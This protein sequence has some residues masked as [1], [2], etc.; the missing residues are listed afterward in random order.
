MILQ[1][2]RGRYAL[3]AYSSSMIYP[4]TNRRKAVTK[5]GIQHETGKSANNIGAYLRAYKFAARKLDVFS[6]AGL[7]VKHFILVE[8][9][10]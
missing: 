4:G 5:P 3:T 2:S 6:F 1:T 7:S 9:T 10:I 8:V